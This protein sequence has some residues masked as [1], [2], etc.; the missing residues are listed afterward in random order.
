[1]IISPV[2]P[3]AAVIELSAA[4]LVSTW[5]APNVILEPA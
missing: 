5:P 3:T 2:S 4:A 1:M